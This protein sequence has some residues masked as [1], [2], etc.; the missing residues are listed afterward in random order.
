MSSIVEEIYK[1]NRTRVPVRESRRQRDVLSLTSAIE[2]ANSRGKIALIAE[3]KRRSPSGFVN[4][5]NPDIMKYYEK[6]SK[7]DIDA[8]SVLCEPDHFGGNYSDITKVQGFMKP[9]LAKDFISSREMIISSYNAGADVVLLIAD[10]LS[11]E[12]LSDLINFSRNLGLE[13]ILEFHSL[14]EIEKVNAFKNVII[15]Y[16]RR[17]L[18]TMEVEGGEEKAVDLIKSSDFPIILESGLS[19]TNIS[20]IETSKFNGVLIGSSILKDDNVISTLGALRVGE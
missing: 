20:K 2:S 19:S 17:N 4:D 14:E 11:K 1:N 5:S 10:F 12:T 13:V 7:K 16:N 6:I 9:V 3:Y 8:M 18:K 15:G